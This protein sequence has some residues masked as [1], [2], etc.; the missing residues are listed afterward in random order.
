MSDENPR[1]S[2]PEVLLQS[3]YKICLFDL[4]AGSTSSIS[5]FKT[6]IVEIDEL[7]EN[8]GKA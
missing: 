1:G 3:V 6:E 4:V 7:K 5:T 8:L 2:K